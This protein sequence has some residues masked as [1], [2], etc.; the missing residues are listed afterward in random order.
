MAVGA[1]HH[2]DDVGA[3][4]PAAHLALVAPLLG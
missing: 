4:R 2:G 3:R 1:R